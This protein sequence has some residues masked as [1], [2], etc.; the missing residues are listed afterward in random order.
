MG[1]IGSMSGLDLRSGVITEDSTLPESSSSSSSDCDDSVVR[2]GDRD[3]GEEYTE[4]G[5][6]GEARAD[7]IDW[8][9][10]ESM[11][12]AR[13]WFLENLIRSPISKQYHAQDVDTHDEPRCNS[14]HLLPTLPTHDDTIGAVPTVNDPKPGIE[15]T[16]GKAERLRLA[17]FDFSMVDSSRADKSSSRALLGERTTSTSISL[18]FRR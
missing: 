12:D 3:S 14:S 13:F 6:C 1:C 10:S 18:D 4:A 2:A 17:L 11:I 7:A 15:E 5:V 16:G 9:T 8:D